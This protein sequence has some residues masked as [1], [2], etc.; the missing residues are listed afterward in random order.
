VED[1]VVL[2]VESVPA[3]RR[4][5]ERVLGRR[6]GGDYR[7][8]TADSPAAALELLTELAGAQRQVA[9][10]MADMWLPGSTGVALLAQVRDLHPRASRVLLFTFGDRRVKEPLRQAMGLGY[11]QYYLPKD[12]QFPEQ[13]LYPSVSEFLSAW[14]K[15]SR[16]G[17][18]AVRVVGEQ[19]TRRCHDLRDTLAANGVPYGFYAVD[20][21]EGRTLL[22]RHGLDDKK[23][24]VVILHDG[25]V[26]LDPSDIQIAEALGADT[27]ADHDEYDLVIVGGGPAGLAAAVYAASE[28]LVT[29]V[30]ERK[31]IGGQAGA[32]ALI[33]NY[34]GFPRGVTGGDLAV[35]AYEQA[36]LFGAD[37]VFLR[38]A[39]SLEVDGESRVVRLSGGQ[40]IRGRGVLVATGMA[41]RRLASP[42]L[43][44][45]QGAGVYYGAT[46]GE[47]RAMEGLTVYVAGG[48][49]SAGQAA[50]HLA[51][52]A[53]QVVLLVRGE[54]LY[55]TM[56]G[57]LI[58]EI[59]AARNVT[60]RANTEVVDGHGARRLEGLTLLDLRNGQVSSVEAAALFV[61]IGAEP[62]TDWL[63]GTVLRDDQGYLL[64]GRDLPRHDPGC[65]PL[66]RAPLS[67]E[68]SLPG[69]FAAGDVRHGSVKRVASAVGEGAVAV[70]ELHE[71]L[72]LG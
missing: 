12:W 29:A 59:Q 43:E 40:S 22:R 52:Y 60:V 70:Q 32:S 2:I 67:L 5:L 1:P 42:A 25:T 26:F 14:S 11:V 24:P 56:S 28:G 48:G 50:L 71:Y 72:S 10:V 9:L 27:R 8:L 19:W 33:R 21:E 35:R 20:S 57:Y 37:F 47:A 65:W 44:A 16:P 34:L 62:Y 4:A 38:G 41:Y 45:L 7:V 6:F 63:A 23:L 3:A 46:A 54:S 31:S 51:R 69:V 58:S 55:S 39:K 15:H 13:W 36:E 64:T 49:N 66:G 68:T 30:I 61:L 17:F 53:A 18:E